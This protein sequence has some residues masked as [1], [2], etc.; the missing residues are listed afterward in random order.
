[1]SKEMLAV[2]IDFA[3]KNQGNPDYNAGMVA[4][5]ARA[6]EYV[7]GPEYEVSASLAK[8]ALAF[9]LEQDATKLEKFRLVMDLF[10]RL[11]K[12]VPK[13]YVGMPQNLNRLLEQ[14]FAECLE[15]IAY[16][17]CYGDWN[18]GTALE[19]IL[20]F[21]E[22]QGEQLKF[23]ISSD[24][25]ESILFSNAVGKELDYEYMLLYV[26]LRYWFDYMNPTI[27]QEKINQLLV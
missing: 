8:F 7:N 20:H 6:T 24:D 1:M 2:L 18:N 13:H 22:P 25:D 9:F 4:V 14:N 21:Q 19:I 26:Y 10:N 3:Q 12:L 5:L 16:A 23:F 27:V 15:G 11:H 17:G